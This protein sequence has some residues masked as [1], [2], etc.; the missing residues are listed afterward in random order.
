MKDI[1]G[2]FG[3]RADA[4]ENVLDD[5]FEVLG[6]VAEVARHEEEVFFAVCAR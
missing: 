2:V 4:I 5:N 3:D 6:L 1:V